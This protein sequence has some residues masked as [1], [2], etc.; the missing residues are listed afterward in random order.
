MRV[1]TVPLTVPA[2]ERYS[3]ILG[4]LLIN[5]PA[6]CYRLLYTCMYGARYLNQ[7]WGWRIINSIKFPH[8]VGVSASINYIYK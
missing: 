6:P 1:S 4:V 5:G 8:G 7:L 3:A 2:K